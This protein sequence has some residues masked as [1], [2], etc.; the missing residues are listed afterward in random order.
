MHDWRIIGT[1]QSG[2]EILCVFGGDKVDCCV[3][4]VELWTYAELSEIVAARYEQ[5][6]DGEWVF[7]EEMPVRI[8]SRWSKGKMTIVKL[9]EMRRQKEIADGTLTGR[10]RCGR[11]GRVA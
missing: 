8:F 7:R 6:L 3:A 4:I 2:V 1:D 5:F 10:A 9:R 11:K